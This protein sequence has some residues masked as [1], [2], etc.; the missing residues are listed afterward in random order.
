MVKK[1]TIDISEEDWG[2]VLK[3]KIDMKKRVVNDAVVD[4]I[5][6]GLAYGKKE[7][8]KNDKSKK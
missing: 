8:K 2:E 6:K 3:Y 4:L 5:K 7:A 1:H